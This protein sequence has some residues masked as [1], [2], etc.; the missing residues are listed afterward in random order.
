MQPDIAH[1]FALITDGAEEVILRRRASN[2][3]LAVESAWRRSAITREAE[4]SGGTAVAA[5]AQWY[6]VLAEN[7]APAVGDL[8]IDAADGHWTI[9]SFEHAPLLGRWKCAVRELRIAYGCGERVDIERPVWSEGETPEIVDWQYV[10]TALPVRIQPIEVGLDESDAEQAEFR[11]ILGESI[12][13]E[14]HDRF[15]AA[16][17]TIYYLRSYEQAQRIDALPVATVVRG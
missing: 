13:L 4:P 2:T 9:L 11:V 7:D 15:V 17:G 5:D 12:E 16:D 14:A 3:T 1:D 10:A 8:I 6:V